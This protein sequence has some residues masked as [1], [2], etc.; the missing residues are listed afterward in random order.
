MINYKNPQPNPTVPL[1]F[2]LN[3]LYYSFH[4][5]LRQL[6]HQLDALSDDEFLEQMARIRDQFARQHETLFP[7]S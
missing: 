1:Q 4:L 3:K 7:E 5:R 2:R 6:G